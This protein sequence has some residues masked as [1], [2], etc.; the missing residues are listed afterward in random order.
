MRGSPGFEQREV[1]LIGQAVR[2]HRKGMPSLGPFAPL[3]AKGDAERLARMATLLRLAEDLERSRDQLVREAHVAVSDGKVRLELVSSGDD[4][5][6]R[7]AAG[8]ELELFAGAFDRSLPSSP[9]DPARGGLARAAGADRDDER[10]V[11]AQITSASSISSSGG[12]TP[13][14]T[15][16]NAPVP[17]LASASRTRPAIVSPSSH[18]IRSI[19]NGFILTVCGG[20][21]QRAVVCLLRL[22]DRF[23]V[24][25]LGDIP[26]VEE[27]PG[28]E[29]APRVDRGLGPAQRGRER[30]GR[31][32]S[33]QAR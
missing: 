16:R 5:V 23:E 15:R 28:V 31:W 21:G 18:C 30:S 29:H 9:A 7:W 33:Y 17:M 4:R 1:A 2:Y 10:L 8:R 6:S 12:S 27:Y 3:A 13:S 26:S 14:Q 25:A 11:G 22:G 19:S 20:N 24:L 32:R